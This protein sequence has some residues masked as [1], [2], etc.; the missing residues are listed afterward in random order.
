[1]PVHTA[2]IGVRADMVLA[3]EI[4]TDPPAEGAECVDVTK[5][6]KARLPE[7]VRELYASEMHKRAVQAFALAVS[8][9]RDA[10]PESSCRVSQC[11]GVEDLH[12]VEVDCGD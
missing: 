6:E 8:W 5:D 4:V 3:I 1:M 2:P 10:Y 11:V 12:E 7:A 9:M